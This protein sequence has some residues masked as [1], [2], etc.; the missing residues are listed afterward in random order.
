MRVGVDI[1]GVVCNS[2]P[3]W[4]QE[5]NRYYQKNIT[6]ITDYEMHLLFDVPWDDMNDFFVKNAET[7]LGQPEPVKGAKEG[8]E[9]LIREGH[10]IIYVTAR[11]PEEKDMTLK[12][13]R[14]HGIPFEH[15]LFTG[16]KSKVDWVKQW[17]MKVFIEDY[18]KNAK[19][20]AAAGVPVFLLDANYNRE[21]TAQGVTR[22]HSWEEILA[23][24][25]TLMAP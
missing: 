22:C 2:Y 8:I 9:S 1:D 6:A 10:E 7:L 20:I 21:E 23:G 18:M 13:F 25:R 17:D 15:V 11:T 12:W 5:L 16:F 4:L 14:K 24:I 19:A 3:L